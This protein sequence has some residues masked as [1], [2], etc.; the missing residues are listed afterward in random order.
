MFS[1]T[2]RLPLLVAG[3][4]ALGL[5]SC[6]HDDPAPAAPV[7]TFR[8]SGGNCQATCPVTFQNTSQNATAYT[9]DFGDNTTGTQAD[10]Q[11]THT[12]A[13]AGVYQV[14]LTAQG[15]S[16]RVTTTQTVT[17]GTSCTPTIVQVTGTITTATTWEPCTVYVVNGIVN[18]TAKLTIQAGTVVKFKPGGGLLLNTNGQLAAAGTATAPVYFTSYHDDAHGGDT[19]QNAAATA[20]A[21]K[22]WRSVNLNGT[23][24]SALTYCQLLYGG[25]G[26]TAL[27]L[28]TSAPSVSYCTFAH[29]GEDVS[30]IARA[31]VNAHYAT[32][33]T[34]L[35]HNVFYDNVRPLSI[36]SSFDLDDSNTFHNPANTSEKNQYQGIVTYW[37]ATVAKPTVSWAETELAYVNTHDIDLKTGHVLNLGN[38]VTVKLMPSVQA[39][40]RTGTTSQLLNATGPGVAFTS[41]R[42][43]ARGG[44]SNGDGAATIPAIGDWDGIY[45]DKVPA[46]WLK[47]PNL[48]Y[49]AH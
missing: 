20:P 4:A 29:N 2:Y 5:A 7:A 22:D 39:T 43:D 23:A 18:V 11:F 30:T 47:W 9:W 3:L 40:C 45:L 19:N 48:Y 34:V 13:K 32:A 44:D 10:P 36:T 25:E 27:D 49:V 1:R 37:D 35:Q 31:V 21:K 15:G 42:D 33:G 12:Y 6:K 41:L 14:K 28:S 24:G 16:G 26:G 38:D 46:E 17:V 8:Y